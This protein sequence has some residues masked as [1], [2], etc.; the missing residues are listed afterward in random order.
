MLIL[1]N[2]FIFVDYSRLL[3]D[4]LDDKYLS[5]PSY[6]PPTTN[7]YTSHSKALNGH[8]SKFIQIYSN[9]WK[10]LTGKKRKERSLVYTQ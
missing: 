3:D 9:I 1:C 6:T 7:K 10:C 2:I 8:D 5:K 4:D